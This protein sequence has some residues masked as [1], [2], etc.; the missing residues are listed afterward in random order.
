MNT[1]NLAATLAVRHRA[2]LG[3]ALAAVVTM[4]ILGQ[5][6]TAYATATSILIFSLI[7]IPLAL[8]YGH[9][10]IVSLC[11]ATFAGMGGYATAILTVNYGWSAWQALPLAMAVPGV[12]S[13]AVSRPILRL[14]LFALV[15]G[16]VAI[17][18]AW[19]FGVSA[20][21]DTTGGYTGIYGIPGIP[22]ATDDR[23]AFVVIVI[24]V[25]IMIILFENFTRTA[26]GRALNSIRVDP[27]MA[28]STG[29][30]VAHQRSIAFTFA[31]AVA[32]A[33]GWYFALYTGYISPVSLS[34]NQDAAVIFMVVIG[35]RRSSVGPIIGAAIYVLFGDLLPGGVVQGVLFGAVLILIL[36]FMQDGIVSI[37]SPLIRKI[38]N[39]MRT[40]KSDQCKT[41]EYTVQGSGHGD[42]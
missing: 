16:T 42:A 24:M 5:Q 4:L 19:S 34:F 41:Q 32:G 8:I 2:V 35:G 29:T 37:G 40:T 12:L 21:G 10:G 31:A 13:F 14:P 20:A 28:L 3:F 39:N 7:S 15:L 26:R 1:G 25:A 11:Q 17:G 38:S 36:L 27:T 18:E 6:N 9:G 33:A 22:L 30:N 23:Q